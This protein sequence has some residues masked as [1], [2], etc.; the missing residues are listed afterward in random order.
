MKDELPVEV[1]TSL[2]ELEL[3]DLIDAAGELV[4]FADK[5]WRIL[6]CNDAYLKSTGLT[7]EQVIGHTPFSY[8][9]AFR[10]TMFFEPIEKCRLTGRPAAAL[11][12]S[13]LTARCMLMRVLPVADGMLMLAND[14]SESV[15]KQY[16]QQLVMSSSFGSSTSCCRRRRT[17]AG[18]QASAH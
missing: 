5:S 6:F 3:T 1:K 13:T 14:A 16:Q 8:Q 12:Y 10:R 17:A 15:I 4:V 2:R 18:W 11:G 9:P 7:R